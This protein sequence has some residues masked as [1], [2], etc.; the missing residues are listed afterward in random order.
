MDVF[1]Q[2]T[3][4]RCADRLLDLSEPQVMGILNC[5]PDSFYDGGRWSDET[6]AL[7]QAESMLEAGAAILDVGGYSTRSGAAEVSEAEERARVVPII[8]AIRQRFP[9]ALISIDTF[10]ASVARAAVE[11]GADLVNDVSAGLWD[12]ALLPEVARMKVP[13][14]LMHV[15]GKPQTM[16][17]NPQYEDVV[18]EVWDFFVERIRVARQ[19]GI[20]EIVLDL[21]FGFGKNVQHNYLLFKKLHLYKALGLPILVGVSRKSMIWKYLDITPEQALP[22]TSVLHFAALQQGAHLLR[23]HD[24]R[25]AVQAIRIWQALR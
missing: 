14:I 2:S 24:V 23:V 13:Y 21:G 19:C 4:L 7:Q 10:R 15:K 6:L 9:E 25:E 11:A 16:Q 12:E 20:R 17:V 1:Q 18:A 3:L 22:S 8:A 5:T